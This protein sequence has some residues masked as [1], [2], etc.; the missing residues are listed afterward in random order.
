MRPRLTYANVVASLALFV[1]L[2]GSAWAL[3]RESVGSREIINGSV[4]SVELENDD[5]RGVD[6]ERD[7][8]SGSD[9]SDESL[10]ADDLVDGRDSGLDA[11]TLDGNDTSEIILKSTFNSE[12]GA[13]IPSYFDY[14]VNTT[15]EDT[16][17]FRAIEIRTT[18][19][20]REFKVCSNGVQ[21]APLIRYVNGTRSVVNTQGNNDCTATFQPAAGGDFQIYGAGVA[22][23]GVSNSITFPGDNVFNVFGIDAS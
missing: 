12:S 17:E 23:W 15:V 5:V 8:V 9:V 13:R 19:N 6:I 4:R 20:T 10:T 1:A 14:V 18:G 21:P 11:D 16:F 2:G 3:A 22:I 7:A